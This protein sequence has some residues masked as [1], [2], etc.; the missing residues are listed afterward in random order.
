[1]SDLHSSKELSVFIP[2]GK[3]TPLGIRIYPK[4]LSS[5]IVSKERLKDIVFLYLDMHICGF[6]TSKIAYVINASCGPE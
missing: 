3:G 6:L 2:R 1:M 5:A 4:G